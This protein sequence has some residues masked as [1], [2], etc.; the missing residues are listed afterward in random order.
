MDFPSIKSDQSHIHE[1]LSES[2]DL[3][4]TSTADRPPCRGMIGAVQRVLEKM[5][6]P[7]SKKSL[8]PASI[9]S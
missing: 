3:L 6:M 9:E 4:K 2:Y 5:E 7:T 1:S 8:S